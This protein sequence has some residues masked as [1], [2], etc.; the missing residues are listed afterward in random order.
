MHAHT[1][2]NAYTRTH[3]HA[4]A[5]TH[6]HKTN[7]KLNIKSDMH[8]IIYGQFHGPFP[9]KLICEEIFLWANIPEDLHLVEADRIGLTGMSALSREC[10]GMPG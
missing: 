9:V 5:R 2:R 3:M 4:H 10:S 1:S 8:S 6:I 7:K